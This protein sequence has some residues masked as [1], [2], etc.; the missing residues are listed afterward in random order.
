MDEG[1]GSMHKEITRIIDTDV[2]S[3][4][5]S[6]AGVMAAIFAA[7]EGVGVT[8]VSKGK[9][10]FSGNAIMAGGGCGIDGESG[11]EILGIETADPSFTRD[12]LF[13]CLVKESFYLAE[14]NL[15]DQYVND[16]PLALKD[17][18]NWGAKAGCKF[19]PIQPCGWQASGLHFTRPL[20]QGLKETPEVAVLE[21]T[22]I[23]DVLYKDNTITGAIGFHV[24]SGDLIQVNAK[25]VVLGTG[26]YQPLTLKNTVSDMT[27][28]GQAMAYRAGAV[29]SDMEFMLAFP[30]ALVPEDMTGS[31][32]PYIFR[33]IPH[34]LADK[35]GNEIVISDTA[36]RLS[37]E[38]K[39]N[40]IVNC[41]YMGHAVA[42][43]RG[44][45]HGGAFWDYSQATQDEK[46]LGFDR[47]YKRFALWHKKG[48]YKGES[49]KRIEEMIFND[50]PIEVG[51]GIEYS[52][53]GIVVNEKMETN[54]RGLLAA[55]EVTAGTFGACR[56]GDGLIEMLAHGMKAGQVAAEYCKQNQKLAS[57][58]LQ[59]NDI[60]DDML[61]YFEHTDG[62]NAI[63]F[64]NA[65]EQAC[66]KGLG[67]IRD[68]AGITEA[69]HQV[70]QMKGKAQNLTVSSKSRA[71]NFEWMRAMQAQ[72]MLICD[73]AALKAAL[74]RRESRG[75]HI[76]QD[77]PEVNHDQYLHHYQFKR[78]GEE[79]EMTTCKPT[80]TKMQPPSGLSED[81]I[82]YFT[83]PQLNYDRSFKINFD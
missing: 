25:V 4:G 75:C 40:K 27:G 60:V 68:E 72:N 24:Y 64:Y 9:I 56:I 37:T 21:D 50:E 83:D 13:D 69:L 36:K 57:D 52:I 29:L 73:E 17:Y 3:V 19:V 48:Y 23:T 63:E 41:F 62:P 61:K 80:I 82:S 46:R 67:V 15:V 1:G 11:K 58:P 6:G 14:Q 5:G 76:R 71:Y 79:M 26:G 54:V 70:L 43:G 59:V 78:R 20:I 44:G 33:R 51:L 45:P 74:E 7:R 32:Y 65:L 55:G 28:D 53:G 81:I 10:G 49:M 35:N 31:I 12:K 47:F 18:L 30:T 77:Y 38:S 34:R 42:Q 22:I 2:L 8:L 39:L 66:D 16:A